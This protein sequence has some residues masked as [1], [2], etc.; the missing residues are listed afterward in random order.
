MQMLATS[1]VATLADA[2]DII[3]CSFPSE[4]FEPTSAGAWSAHYARFQEY[5]GLTCA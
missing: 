1:A 2:R 4:R 5:V 3:Q